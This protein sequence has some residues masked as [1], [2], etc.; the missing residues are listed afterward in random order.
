MGRKK[1]KVWPSRNG[2]LW[3]GSPHGH[4]WWICCPTVALWILELTSMM[5][6]EILATTIWELWRK[7]FWNLK[8]TVRKPSIAITSWNVVTKTNWP[9]GWGIECQIGCHPPSTPNEDSRRRTPPE[10]PLGN[11]FVHEYRKE[12]SFLN[13]KFTHC[14]WRNWRKE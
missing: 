10:P 13:E 5:S 12:R 14:N 9:S 7:N 6:L 3:W 8:R 11:P 2:W 4:R 1:G